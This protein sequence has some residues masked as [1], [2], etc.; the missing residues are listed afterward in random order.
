[1][2]FRLRS[3]AAIGLFLFVSACG[4][5][6]ILTGAPIYNGERTR[7][8]A[9]D[10][11]GTGQFPTVILGNPS[12]LSDEAFQDA[13]L[14]I[15]RLPAGLP[16]TAFTLNPDPPVTHSYRL[17]LVFAP[18]SRAVSAM[19]ICSEEA[20]IPL[21]RAKDEFFFLKAVYCHRSRPL[22][23]TFGETTIADYRGRKFHTLMFRVMN[24]LFPPRE[25]DAANCIPRITC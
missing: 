12:K 6:D 13:V 8:S 22:S 2:P 25:V 18:E 17:V 4:T 23:E 9:F 24:A 11:A 20:V 14:S 10:I 16:V 21:S 19:T 7:S 15:L 3:F 5:S 1:M